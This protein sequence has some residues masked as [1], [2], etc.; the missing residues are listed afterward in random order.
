MDEAVRVTTEPTYYEQHSE[1]MELWSP[2]NDLFRPP[3]AVPND[4]SWPPGTTL[5]AVLDGTHTDDH[6]PDPTES[7]A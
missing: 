5:A 3:E 4:Q 6:R 1:S 7:Q 2:G